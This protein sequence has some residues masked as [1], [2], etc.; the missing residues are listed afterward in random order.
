M[1]RQTLALRGTASRRWVADHPPRRCQGSKGTACPLPLRP[2]AG[3]DVA[4]DGCDGCFLKE[5]IKGGN[6]GSRAV[7]SMRGYFSLG[8]YNKEPYCFSCHCVN[9]WIVSCHSVK[10]ACCPFGT[11]A[12]AIWH[13]Q[14]G[15]GDGVP[16][17]S[18]FSNHGMQWH[19][20]VCNLARAGECEGT[21]VP[22]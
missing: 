5:F 7:S 10:G 22:S 15:V 16:P 11:L 8:C 14:G 17:I 9:S 13:G 4:C 18:L 1:S 12:L 6:V 19:A 2:P 3:S 21:A 20:M